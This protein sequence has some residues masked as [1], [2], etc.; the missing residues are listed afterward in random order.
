MSQQEHTILVPEGAEGQRLDRFLASALGESRNRVQRRIAD[1]CIQVDGRSV[2]ASFRV[3]TGEHILVIEPAAAAIEEQ[4]EPEPLSEDLGI[5][6]EADDYIV[7][8]KPPGLIVH[9][10]AGHDRGTLAHQLLSRYPEI[11]RVGH[12]QRPG[13]VHRLDVGTSGVMVVARSERGYLALSRAFSTRQV[14]KKYLAIVYGD[15]LFAGHAHYQK[16]HGDAVIKVGGDQTA[17]ETLA[18]RPAFDF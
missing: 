10:G 1:D 2:N 8:S 9:P 3:S 7:V 6:A 17:S 14:R 5:V 12:P 18:I 4:L 15:R 11:S 16:A 13:I